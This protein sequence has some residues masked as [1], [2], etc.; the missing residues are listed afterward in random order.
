M[1]TS[2]R[3]H[4]SS[5]VFG[6]PAGACRR[7]SKTACSMMPAP[8]AAV[9]ESPR[10]S[11]EPVPAPLRRRP[12]PAR[13]HRDDGGLRGESSRCVHG[14][15]LSGG[16]PCSVP[17]FVEHEPGCGAGRRSMHLVPARM[18]PNS[19]GVSIPRRALPRAN[20]LSGVSG[21]AAHGL[22]GLTGTEQAPHDPDT[23]T[24]GDSPN[25]ARRDP[26]RPASA[27]TRVRGGGPE[28]GGV[29]TG[30]RRDGPGQGRDP[31]RRD[32]RSRGQDPRG[33]PEAGERAGPGRD[34]P[35]PGPGPRPPRRTGGRG[36][37]RP[38]AQR[39]GPG[40][41]PPR[42]PGGRRGASAP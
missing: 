21:A 4:G 13:P 10:T 34:G 5:P 1:A 20:N 31:P 42:R 40:P 30:P 15:F 2:G 26:R 38:G 18:V 14:G 6:A 25:E 11:R 8:N 41:R 36:T 37:S 32:G 16:R 12:P 7:R 24:G 19:D 27:A 35:G 33:A 28:A 23:S 17:G 3:V 29:R 9:S 22:S 39:L